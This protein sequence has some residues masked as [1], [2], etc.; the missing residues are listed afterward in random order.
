[1]K[2]HLIAALCCLGLSAAIP[3]LA[4]DT[5]IC[6]DCHVPA[7]DWE[8]LTVDDVLAAALDQDIAR[9][10]GNEELGEEQ[11]RQMIETMLAQ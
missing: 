9:H 8:G 6:L 11:L 3:V 7:E 1:M 5:E 10:A 2:K 4:E